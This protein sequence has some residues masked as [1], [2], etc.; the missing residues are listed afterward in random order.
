MPCKNQFAN[1]PFRTISKNGGSAPLT[2]QRLQTVLSQLGPPPQPVQL[3]DA[4]KGELMLSI[5]ILDFLL[6]E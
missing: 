2:Y 5:K 3:G 1:I 4:L 6:A